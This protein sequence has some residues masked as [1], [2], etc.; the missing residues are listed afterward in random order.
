MLIALFFACAGMQAQDLPNANILQ[1]ITTYRDLAIS[2]MQRTGVPAAIKLAQGILET[3]AGRSDLVMRSNNHFGIKC[4]SWWTGEKVYHDDDESGECFRKYGSSQD[5]YRDHSDYLK[6]QP[7]YAFLFDMDPSDYKSW[8]W[9]LKKAG[10]ATNPKYPQQLIKYI[11]QYNLAEYTLIAMGKVPDPRMS[12]PTAESGPSNGGQAAQESAT[13]L[14]NSP[15]TGPGGKNTPGWPDGIF[16]IN[17]TRVI[18]AKS[19]TSLLALAEQYGIRFSWL[20]D[21]NDLPAGIDNLPSDQLIFLQRKRKQGRQAYHIVQAGETVHLIS[22]SE[23]IR[24]ESLLGLNL[25]EPGMEPAVGQVLHLQE[26]VSIRPVLAAPMAAAYRLTESDPEPVATP[27]ETRQA[28]TGTTDTQK[29][30]VQ[31]KETLFS[32][33][34][35]YQVSTVQIR[36]WNGLQSD[37]LK[38]GQELLIY[39]NR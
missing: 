24:L 28:V 14:S 25:L 39:K 19:G 33:A 37:E 38:Q 1:Y 15:A 29:H 20:I 17:E 7:R 9:G 11:E 13:T 32:L 21:F 8:A 30:I 27:T 3:D 26:R 5:S 16:E 35:K 18:Y 36:E 22:Q 23:G 6:S 10:Y 4:K 31:Q 2:E 34:R 12:M